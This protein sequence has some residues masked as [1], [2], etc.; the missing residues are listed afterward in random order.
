MDTIFGF[1]SDEDKS[2]KAGTQGGTFGLNT[3]AKLVKFE[4]NPNGG[5]DNSEANCLDIEIHIGEKKFMQRHY[6]I[7]KVYSKKGG[8]ITDTTSK[9]YIEAYNEVAKHQK[10]L[11]THYLKIFFTEEEIKSSFANATIKNFAD[12]YKFVA[13]AI[14]IGVQ[15]KGAEIDIF[16]QYQWN[17]NSG[18]SRTFLE[19]P[20]NMKD[21]AFVCKPIPVTGKWSE[22]KDAD[23]LH[24]IDE[25][26]NKHR[27][28]RT[29]NYL[30]SNKAIQQ[31]ENESSSS[32]SDMGA[33]ASVPAGNGG[34]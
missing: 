12:Y 31:V 11:I 34:W 20:K 3:G 6:E 13:D 2:L 27:F 7:T 9:E 16:L 19:L 1:Q 25:A 33:G 24:Y 8:E 18:Q 10:G 21:G 4:F 5:K 29:V 17:I 22:V 32:S 14:K 26:G 23:G 30:Q 28:T 15:R